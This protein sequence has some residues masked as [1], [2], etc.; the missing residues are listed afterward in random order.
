MEIKREQQGLNILKIEKLSKPYKE[1]RY[2]R[3]RKQWVKI[4]HHLVYLWLNPV[5]GGVLGED[6]LLLRTTEA[7]AAV[8][9]GLFNSFNLF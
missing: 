6:R 2:V 3:G 1:H 5:T 8:K 7:N 9:R 4:T